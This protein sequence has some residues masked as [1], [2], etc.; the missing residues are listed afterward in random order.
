VDPEGDEA[1]TYQWLL[2]NV[3]TG[4]QVC[5]WGKGRFLLY[6]HCNNMAVC[7]SGASP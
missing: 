5:A 6:H 7:R 2:R 4:Q 1:D 3:A